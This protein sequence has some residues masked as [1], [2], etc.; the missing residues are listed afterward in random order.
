VLCNSQ[1]HLEI[2]TRDLDH[3]ILV[4]AQ[5]TNS[6]CT[7]KGDLQCAF[8]LDVPMVPSSTII[9][10]TDVEH[11]TCGGFP[12]G[13]TIRLGSFEFIANY[14]CGLSLSPRRGDLG[15]A[16][17]GSTRSGTPSLQRAMIED[18]TEEFLM[19]SSGEGASASPLLGGAAW[20]LRT[21][22]SQPHYGWRTL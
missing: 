7:K 4:N 21:L 6:W 22:P 11:L 16:F 2:G 19:A 17:M 10:A 20:G 14:F 9:I 3:A 1:D 8:P 12:L 13:K 15:A 5:N 18:S